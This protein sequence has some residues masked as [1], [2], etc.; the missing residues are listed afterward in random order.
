MKHILYPK[1]L[2]HKPH[3]SD[4]Y[5]V[6]PETLTRKEM[7]W[8]CSK[9]MVDMFTQICRFFPHFIKIGGM[10]LADYVMT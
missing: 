4:F 9:F 6:S 2:F 5:I 8:F 3:E 10:E 1:H 7:D